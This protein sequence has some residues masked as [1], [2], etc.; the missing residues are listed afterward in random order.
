VTL[1]VDHTVGFL[2]VA[3]NGAA[4]VLEV[5][6]GT[7]EVARELAARGHRVVGVDADSDAV[8]AAKA[9]GVDAVLSRWPSFEH[10]GVF[11]A[12]IFTRSLHHI[13]PLQA[14]VDRA[15][16]ALRAGGLLVIEDFAYADMDSEVLR[17]FAARLREFPVTDEFLAGIRDAADPGTAWHYAHSHELHRWSRMKKAIAR[18]FRITREE[19][20][21][22]LYRYL[23]EEQAQS[24]FDWESTLGEKMLG[25]R[26][27]ATI[28]EPS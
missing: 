12:V 26:L 24:I 17:S 28:A 15:A 11:D 5:G 23:P 18:R 9:N 13:D 8:A 2:E 22:Y 14:A 27:V 21:P 6:C 19:T 3:L 16:D 4:N 25:R 20:A 1:A 10:A 7:G